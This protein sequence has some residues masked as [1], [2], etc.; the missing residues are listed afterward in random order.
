MVS[1]AVV[2]AVVSVAEVS[3]VASAVASAAVH[4]RQSLARN[5]FSEEVAVVGLL[6]PLLHSGPVLV[7]RR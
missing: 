5:R 1:A 3:A 4:H 6:H 2:S 7:K